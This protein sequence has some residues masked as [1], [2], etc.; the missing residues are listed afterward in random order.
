MEGQLRKLRNDIHPKTGA[1]LPPSVEL[2]PVVVPAR[3]TTDEV[4]H[5]A[6]D[7]F[8][9]YV[10]VAL[11]TATLSCNA[12]G[13]SATDRREAMLNRIRAKER[14]MSN[15]VDLWEPCATMTTSKDSTDAAARSARGTPSACPLLPWMRV[16]R[17]HAL[18]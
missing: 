10:P 2:E 3:R 12:E 18:R 17:L 11:P 15:D 6:P 8:Y 16:R 13:L 14:A 7:G 1:W 5:K 9:T 4:E